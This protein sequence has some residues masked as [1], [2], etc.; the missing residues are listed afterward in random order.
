MK[1]L[2]ADG[3]T[4]LIQLVKSTF[5]TKQ[6]NLISG[7]NIKTVNNQSLLGSGNI[8]IQSGSSYTAGDYIDITNNV[9]SGKVSTNTSLVESLEKP[10]YAWTYGN[11]TYY[12]ESSTPTASS[13]LY[14]MPSTNTFVKSTTSE[15]KFVSS[16]TISIK[17]DKDYQAWSYNGN[18][19]YTLGENP[20]V[21]DTLY[22]KE[23]GEFVVYDGL[24]ITAVSSN[25]ITLELASATV[26]V[27]LQGNVNYEC[28]LSMSITNSPSDYDSS[29]YYGNITKNKGETFSF[30]TTIG[31]YIYDI[32][33]DVNSQNFT[34][35]ISFDNG[36]TWNSFPYSESGSAYSAG[37]WYV[38]SVNY[39]AEAILIENDMNILIDYSDYSSG[40]SAN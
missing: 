18:T 35:K 37:W 31:K 21:G 32:S 19:Y 36:N 29:E 17:E 39:G 38:Y 1:V 40:G 8:T 25:S 3:L 16:G 7:T 4:K 15:I 5:S 34:P 6:D 2:S 33:F 11:T 22:T 20:Q 30:N 26:N 12:T 9:I 27:I 10:Y 14:T 13:D 28:N 24:K 23:N